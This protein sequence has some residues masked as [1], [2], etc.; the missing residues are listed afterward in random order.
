[1]GTTPTSSGGFVV[2]SDTP[3][4][5]PPPSSSVKSVVP[6]SPAPVKG[7]SKKNMLIGLVVVFLLVSTGLVF[8]FVNQQQSLNDIRN[9]A[10]SP[11]PIPER[12]DGI[13]TP[14]AG[15]VGGSWY[16]NNQGKWGCDMGGTI[17]GTCPDPTLTGGGDPCR[18]NGVAVSC[19]E[20]GMIRCNCGGNVWVA[21][22]AQGGTTCSDL[23]EGVGY[24]C[25]NSCREHEEPAVSPTPTRTPTA[26]PTGTATPTATVTVTPSVTITSTPTGTVSVT[27]SG[28]P[29]V[30]LTPTPT[31]IVY[32]ACNGSCTVNADCGGSLVCLDRVCRNPSCV[33]SSSCSCGSAVPTPKIPVAGTGPSVLGATAIA[34]GFFLLLLGL[35]F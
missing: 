20:V 18:I 33:E 31:Q 24:T 28:T 21:G 2:S 16:C 30:T 13:A 1:M 22:S 26:T 25:G 10:Y 14:T 35:L 19:R 23:C 11:P 5:P 32:A 9:R 4:S 6:P 27:P 29:S 12:C 8:V 15:C 34:G 17:T 3:N 7:G